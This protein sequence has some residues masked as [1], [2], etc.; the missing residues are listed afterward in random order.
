M[1]TGENRECSI[2]RRGRSFTGQITVRPPNNQRLRARVKQ[3]PMQNQASKLRWNVFWPPI[4]TGKLTLDPEGQA[5][6][7]NS[8]LLEA[9]GQLCRQHS[10]DGLDP[11]RPP[12]HP[13]LHHPTSV[14]WGGSPA[15]EGSTSDQ[16]LA[17]LNSPLLPLTCPRRMD[18]DAPWKQAWGLRT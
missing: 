15:P 9:K 10:R 16:A 3:R 11:W 7:Q 4:L 5:R 17:A 6:V 2:C 14:L 18:S 12:D 8:P 13:L 1:Q